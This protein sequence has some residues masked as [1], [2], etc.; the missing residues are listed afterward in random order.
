M[1]HVGKEYPR[2][3]YLDLYVS[4]SIRDGQP[5]C[6]LFHWTSF[7]SGT[8]EVAWRNLNVV[9]TVQAVNPTLDEYLYIFHHP[10]ID[11]RIELR[12]TLECRFPRWVNNYNCNPRHK[13]KFFYLGT[14]IGE[15]N[16]ID[17]NIAP[18]ETSP[19]VGWSQGLAPLPGVPGSLFTGMTWRLFAASWAQQPAYK[20]L[21]WISS[22]GTE[23]IYGDPI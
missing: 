3:G 23:N 18:W 22:P 17:T 16:L 2:A 15:S 13:C 8:A 11:S 20:P 10:T 21:N 9:S 19:G 12:Q 5:R 6:L 4:K 7:G 1:A 14:Q